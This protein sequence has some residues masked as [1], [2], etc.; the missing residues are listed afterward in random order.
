M[1]DTEGDQIDIDSIV[2]GFYWACAMG[3]K[4]VV[5]LL[6][7]HPRL[8]QKDMSKGKYG[9]TPFFSACTRG[10]TDVIKLLL[11]HPR[12]KGIDFKNERNRLGE[13][14][15]EI[16]QRSGYLEIVAILTEYGFS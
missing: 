15:L 4:K 14:P 7:N 12:T 3:R 16:A 8:K 10:Q 13:G 2:E 1:W 11:N 9:C 5:E 6:L